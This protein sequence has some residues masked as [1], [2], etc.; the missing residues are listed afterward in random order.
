MSIPQSALECHLVGMKCLAQIFRKYHKK[1]CDTRK[2]DE[3]DIYSEVWQYVQCCV[4][5]EEY[6]PEFVDKYIHNYQDL[7]Q[8]G[9]SFLTYFHDHRKEL[10]GNNHL[11]DSP[12]GIEPSLYQEI[13]PI[14]QMIEINNYMYTTSSTN[15]PYNQSYQTMFIEGYIEDKYIEKLN[16][17]LKKTP[18][19]YKI[20]N[21]ASQVMCKDLAKSK[22][23]EGHMDMLKANKWIVNQP[24]GILKKPWVQT[25]ACVYIEDP[26]QSNRNLYK[27]LID[28]LKIIK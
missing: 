20:I 7:L 4:I 5:Y 19:V 1:H 6:I 3:Q 22:L 15:C 9:K 13:W 2:K 17:E 26:V 18:Y 8:Y 12:T 25:L 14:K 24:Y 28:I 11:M 16:D 23:Y 21:S 10:C 27:N